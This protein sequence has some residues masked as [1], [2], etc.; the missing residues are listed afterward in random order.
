MSEKRRVALAALGILG[1]AMIL[2]SCAHGPVPPM[3][4][5][6]KGEFYTVD[7]QE[8]LS[9]AERVAMLGIP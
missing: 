4:D 3:K 9:P 8:R 1:L 2:S 5:P 7:E 6:T